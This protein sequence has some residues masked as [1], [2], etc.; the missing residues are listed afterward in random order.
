MDVNKS[1]DELTPEIYQCQVC[2]GNMLDRKPRSLT[3]GHSFC[4]GCLEKLNKEGRID[5]PTCRCQTLTPDGVDKLP[6][7]FKLSKFKD[8]EKDL[9]LNVDFL[10]QM[11]F[12]KGKKAQ[13]L[14]RCVQ[15]YRTMC[16]SCKDMHN[17]IPAFKE[18]KL[19]QIKP[20]EVSNKICRIHG[21]TISY[22]CH[23]C[24]K[25]ICID[26]MFSA[27]H[28]EHN[29]KIEDFQSGC[30]KARIKAE[31]LEN[32]KLEK[33]ENQIRLDVAKMVE[34]TTTL[35]QQKDDLK[36][37]ITEAESAL[38]DIQHS[39]QEPAEEVKTNVNKTQE[40]LKPTL[41]TLQSLKEKDDHE[42]VAIFNQVIQEATKGVD[43]ARKSLN[44]SYSTLPFNLNTLSLSNKPASKTI[45]LH[46][47]L[48]KKPVEILCLQRKKDES[49]DNE[50]EE[51]YKILL[52]RIIKMKRNPLLNC[53]Q[54]F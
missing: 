33:R 2:W 46:D 12:M 9:V 23:E 38:K 42:F 50:S 44:L 17:K 6:L 51:N 41:V 25:G 34:T 29:D 3:C 45:T 32:A 28:M 18:H 19:D 16:G 13:A 22:L 53:I 40:T 11:C 47:F 24:M 14:V 37:K 49:S 48:E 26:C 4:Q 35:C 10:C 7:D 36:M 21:Q 31:E 1:E 15:C 20:P 52:I 8:M 5:C 54:K 39:Y 30:R 43:E 27:D